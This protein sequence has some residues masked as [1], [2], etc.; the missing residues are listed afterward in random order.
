MFQQILPPEIPIGLG[1]VLA[2]VAAIAVHA[3][4]VNHE[5]EAGALLVEHINQL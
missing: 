1:K 3:V 4:R 2:L 5:L